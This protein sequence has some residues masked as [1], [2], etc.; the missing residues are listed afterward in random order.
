MTVPTDSL[1]TDFRRSSASNA[2]CEI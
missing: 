2:V 1:M